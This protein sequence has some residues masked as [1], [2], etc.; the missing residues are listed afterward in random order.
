MEN[1][2]ACS[3]AL[4]I[5]EIVRIICGEV[6]TFPRHSL[7]SLAR[8]S[9]IFMNPAL[10]NLWS[11]LTGLFSLV[12]CMP[13]TLWEERAEGAKKTVCFRRPII[14]ADL[15]RLLFYS[16][17]VKSFTMEESELDREAL[18]ALSVV[19]TFQSM[20]P[21]LSTLVWTPDDATFPL[22]HQLLGSNLRS[23]ILELDDTIPSLSLFPYIKASCPLVTNFRLSLASMVSPS[24]HEQISDVVCGWQH[25]ELL[26]IPA[27]DLTGFIHV[28]Q[29]PSLTYLHL[30]EGI[31]GEVGHSDLPRLLPGTN[32]FP[33]L[34]SFD[35]A[36]KTSSFC[37]DLV[38]II[39]SRKLYALSIVLL[40]IW[41][42]AT[43][44]ELFTI[45]HQH[46]DHDQLT[47]IHISQSVKCVLP[48]HLVPYMLSAD[49]FRPLLA[50]NGMISFVFQIYPGSTIDDNALAEMA[51]AWPVAPHGHTATLACLI[52]FARFCRILCTLGIRMRTSDIPEFSQVAGDQTREDLRTLNV[53]TSPIV[54]DPETA[55]KVAAFLSNLFPQLEKIN[56]HAPQVHF[57]PFVRYAAGWTSVSQLVPI[58]SS[59]RSQEKNLWDAEAKLTEEDSDSE[60]GDHDG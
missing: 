36:F 42:A 47:S 32:R 27:L 44:E 37:A 57:E 21:R 31:L 45:F 55:G 14:A 56:V 3:R 13:E 8:A 53:G 38:R 34:K 52:P 60:D 5:T 59:V 29:L 11:E 48:V 28:S 12:K 22:A 1:P 35:I 20:M 18:R 51:T 40:Q 9:K 25:L 30:T 50:F 16:V 54:A 17:R 33:A 41:T 15:P 6:P 19:L 10:D 43:W 26:S 24:T 7:S 2:S 58:F 49:A 23:L 39:S 46:L 4:C